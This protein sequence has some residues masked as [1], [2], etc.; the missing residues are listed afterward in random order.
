MC[1]IWMPENNMTLL[2][3]VSNR[4]T[5]T[6]TDWVRPGPPDLPYSDLSPPAPALQQWRNQTLLIEPPDQT[7]AGCDLCLAYHLSQATLC[8]LPP[9]GPLWCRPGMSMKRRVTWVRSVLHVRWMMTCICKDIHTV[10][11]VMQHPFYFQD[12]FQY[13]LLTQSLS[14]SND[15]S[16]HCFM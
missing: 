15:I 2:T 7:A 11:I 5:M 12:I 13:S 4:Y 3:T 16:H 9:S 8:F 1:W 6:K 10:T 14:A